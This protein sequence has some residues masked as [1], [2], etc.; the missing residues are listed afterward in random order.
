MQFLTSIHTQIDAAPLKRK[1]MFSIILLGAYA[2]GFH[3]LANTRIH[4]EHRSEQR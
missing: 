4:V 2:L 1:C 3:F